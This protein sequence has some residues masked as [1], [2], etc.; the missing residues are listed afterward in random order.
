MISERFS[1][2]RY[3]FGAYLKYLAVGKSLDFPR[4]LQIQTQS[5]CNGRCSICPYTVVS[6]KLDQG[7]MEWDLFVKIAQELSLEPLLSKV[8]FE[9]H[10]E[11]LLDKRIFEWVKYIKTISPDKRCAIVTNGELL[12]RFTS[13]EIIQSNLDSLV[14]SLNA[15][16]KEIYEIT[17]NGLDYNKVMNNVSHLLSN[18]SM[19]SKIKLSF[20]LTA[21]N[22][23]DVYQ[24]RRYWTKSGIKTRVF[25]IENRGGALD[26]YQ[27]IRP[28]NRYYGRTLLLKGWRRLMSSTRGILGCE[29]PFRQ[30]CILFNG[31]VI[32][33]C[34]DWNRATIVGNVRTSSLKE[35]WNSE[36]MNEIRRLIVKKRYE[37]IN[38]CKKCSFIR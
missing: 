8:L 37:Q 24:A 20:V 1:S 3:L 22:R 28:K 2:Y 21:Q 30:M 32:L 17:N 13:S 26:N 35:I 27:S 4:S 9:L 6:K 31:D 23:H 12:D 25:D 38:S 19:R 10:N 18:Q 14:I 36:K 29:L 16:S 34:H 15:H 7:T 11:P 5:F 33:C